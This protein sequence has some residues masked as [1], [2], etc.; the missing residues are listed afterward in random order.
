ME[1]R[2]MCPHC[3]AFITTRDRV[4]P[5]CQET[6][7][8][9]AIETR[10]AGSILGGFIPHARFTTT[11]ILLL[12]AAL[13][14]ATGLYSMR[15]G[16]GNLID[17]DLQ[18]LGQ[19]GAKYSPFIVQYGQWWRL[20]TAGF[21]HGGLMHIAMNSWVLFDLGAQV[22]E[23]FGPARLIVIYFCSTVGGFT[24]SM[25]WSPR[26]PSVGASAGIMGLIGT[27]IALGMMHRSAVGAAIRGVYVRY[28]IY[29]LVFGLL[30]FFSID[31]AAHIGGL[32]TGFGVTWLA[33]LPRSERHG[34]EQFWRAASYVCLGLTGLSFFKM[35]MAF[36]AI[37]P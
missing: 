15:S 17:I 18:T 36:A 10:D 6:V 27:M 26:V 16:N 7:G 14:L 24:A 37:Q 5:Y 20:V 2:R 21:L 4:C 9:R 32:A 22:E 35:Y 12:N 19:F 30:P 1:T 25:F 34:R 8:P 11:M 28:A 23:V 3:R 31:N 13:Y 29:V 33:G